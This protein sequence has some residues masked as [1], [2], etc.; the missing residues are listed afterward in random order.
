M[1]MEKLNIQTR[2]G[3]KGNVLTTYTNQAGQFVFSQDILKSGN[4]LDVITSMADGRRV[5][6]IYEHDK[7][8]YQTISA[9]NGTKYAIET[10]Q[11]SPLGFWTQFRSPNGVQIEAKDSRLSIGKGSAIFDFVNG[12]H[13]ALYSIAQDVKAEQKNYVLGHRLYPSA[14][15]AWHE[16]STGISETMQIAKQT[17]ESISNDIKSMK[18]PNKQF[19]SVGKQGILSADTSLL[20]P[21][22]VIRA[23][24]KDSRVGLTEY[25]HGDGQ[26]L[27]THR[28]N[29]YSEQRETPQSGF[30]KLFRKKQME[31]VTHSEIICTTH[32][33]DTSGN[34]IS[35][36]KG[37]EA[38]ETVQTM[39][40]Y[41]QQQENDFQHQQKKENIPFQNPL[42]Q[43]KK[44]QR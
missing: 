15:H 39:E 17:L 36:F 27:L 41:F 10:A 34:W 28:Q 19:I 9:A 1:K 8:V 33:I 26:T 22:L 42:F 13:D 14:A 4:M 3:E 40:A 23:H 20:N 16:L 43:G 5:H 18:L 6:E 25:F 11:R 44:L 24:N 32:G 7:L 2:P 29:Q 35:P 21:K 38:V 30:L 31:E 37:K 12:A